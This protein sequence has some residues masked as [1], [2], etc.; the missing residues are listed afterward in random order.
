MWREEGGHEVAKEEVGEGKSKKVRCLGGAWGQ[1]RRGFGEFHFGC[2]ELR[3]LWVL[4]VDTP[5]RE[6]ETQVWS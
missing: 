5:S 2:I 4:R 1:R 6:L 3:S